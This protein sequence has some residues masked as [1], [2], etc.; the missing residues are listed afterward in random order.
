MLAALVA[1]PKD[2]D[3]QNWGCQALAPLLSDPVVA[4][5]HRTAGV[6]AVMRAFAVLQD[7]ETALKSMGADV[8]GG[9][10]RSRGVSGTEIG[11]TTTARDRWFRAAKKVCSSCFVVETFA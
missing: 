8:Q 1:C 9:G 3:V 11:K 6:E 2:A 5:T 7:I 4:A 10:S